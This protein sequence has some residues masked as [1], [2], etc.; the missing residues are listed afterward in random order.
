MTT[1]AWPSGLPQAF[2]REGFSYTLQDNGIRS[3]TD[4]GKPM[5]RRRTTANVE[6][7]SGMMTMTAAQVAAFRTF[8]KDTVKEVL[9]F[10]FPDPFG[11]S[12]LTVEFIAGK[13]PGITNHPQSP[14]RYRVTLT[15][16]VLP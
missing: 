8:Y 4:A 1:P 2:L 3:Q 14:G 16:E 10:T 7:L 13:P 15:M 12:D 9:P 5:Q 6:P 11:G